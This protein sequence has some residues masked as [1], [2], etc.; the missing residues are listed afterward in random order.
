MEVTMASRMNPNEHKILESLA[1]YRILTPG[2][3]AA[4]HQKNKQV[5]WKRLRILEKDGLIQVIK[6]ELGR[7]RG[8]PESLFGL[9]ERGVDT[10]KDKGIVGRDIPNKQI[11][12]ATIRCMDHQI[13]LNWFRIHLN[14]IE[15]V[16]PRVKVRALAHS[17]PF[18]PKDPRG[19]IFITDY[20]PVPG[21][22]A[23]GVKFTPDA[24]I[25]LCDTM[26]SKTCLFFLEV[27]RATETMAS[28]KR[29]TTD[30][31]QKIV[32]YQWYFQSGK[33]RRYEQVFKCKLNGFRL[34]FL[35][36][37]LGRFTTLCR[38]VQEMLPSNFVWLTEC[39]HLFKEG[40]SAKIWAAGGDLQGNQ[41]SI[42][43]S[44]CYQPP[45]H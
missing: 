41:E 2:Q 7:S 31:R 32:N 33:Y 16:I 18:L 20:A 29:D 4:F 12:A 34:L 13:L 19:R 28:P 43:G 6:H 22:S 24:V 38:L 27:D 8:R 23:Q 17:S 26:E 9:T 3:I 5:I 37:S 30:I 44:L 45:S 21:F 42:L 25:G 35:T 15:K 39:G 1:E 40:A 36:N 14:Q 10:L 11:G